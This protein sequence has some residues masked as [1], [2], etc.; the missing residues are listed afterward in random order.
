GAGPIRDPGGSP[1]LP[2]PPRLAASVRA[3]G[4]RG[5]PRPMTER[6]PIRLG[7]IGTGAISQVVHVPIF[8]E[9]TDV[10]VVAL[11]DADPH[12]AEMLARRYGVPRVTDWEELIAD[13]EVE[14][15]VLTT[16]N[17]LHEE[18]CVRALES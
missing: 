6:G 8:S 5:G 17:N 16:P 7:I 2:D 3:S 18:M 12:K 15:V 10:D 4:A 11:A 1:V 13:D 14:A 9:R